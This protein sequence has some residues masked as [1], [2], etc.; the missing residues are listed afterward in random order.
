M[1]TIVAL[2][3]NLCLLLACPS[4]FACG[5]NEYADAPANKVAENLTALLSK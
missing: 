1:K 3:A 4:S 5:G 2:L